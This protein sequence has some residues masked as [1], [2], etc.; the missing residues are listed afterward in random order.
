MVEAVVAYVKENSSA[1]EVWVGDN[2]SLGMHV[3]RAKPAFKESGMEEV[4]IRGGADA[5]FTLMK[6]KL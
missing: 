3:G 1:G 6:L 2:P 4:A 5:L